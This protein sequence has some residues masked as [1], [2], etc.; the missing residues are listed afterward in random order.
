MDLPKKNN[1][2]VITFE[3]VITSTSFDYLDSNSNTD[4]TKMNMQTED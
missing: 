4:T 1:K 2:K 3:E